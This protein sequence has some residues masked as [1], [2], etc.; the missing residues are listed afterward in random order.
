MEKLKRTARVLDRL[1]KIFRAVCVAAAIALSAGLVITTGYYLSIRN[2][3]TVAVLVTGAYNYSMASN[4]N[5]VPRPPIVAL[6][7]G[8]PRL[9]VRRETVEDVAALDL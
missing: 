9:I 3:D 1:A 5:R 8:K 4:Y 2:D 6:K 7:D